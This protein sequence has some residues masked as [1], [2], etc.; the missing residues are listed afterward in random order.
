MEN[1][2]QIETRQDQ[3]TYWLIVA[4]CVCLVIQLYALPRNIT[5]LMSLSNQLLLL[6]WLGLGG[7]FVIKRFTDRLPGYLFCAVWMLAFVVFSV[8]FSLLT[9]GGSMMGNISAIVNFLAF[10]IMLLYAALFR[11]PQRAKTAILVT[12]VVLSLIFIDLYFSGYRNA[13]TNYYGTTNINALTLGYS[14]P[15]QTAMF[16]FVCTIILGISVFYTDSFFLKAALTLDMLFICKMLFDTESR[17][18]FFVVLVFF[19][20]IALTNKRKLTK[21]WILYSIL[22]PLIYALCALFLRSFF[23]NTTFL[24]ESLFNGRELIYDRF[25]NN[26]NLINFILGDFSRFQFDNLHNSYI[27]V[28]ATAGVI[29]LINFMTFLKRGHEKNLDLLDDERYSK[30]AFVGS[31]ATIIYSSSEAAFFVG[32][33]TYAFMIFSIYLFFSRP[34]AEL[35]R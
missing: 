23:E 22:T 6:M 33:S 4:S 24:G 35:N 18:A 11:I 32:G 34:Y 25:L 2:K 19:G 16:L 8:I 5:R 10:P 26:I 15:N 28:V 13:Y 9:S 20:F 3:Y 14:N 29:V 30:V 21:K 31:L 12:N 1:E 27:S 17:T 7:F